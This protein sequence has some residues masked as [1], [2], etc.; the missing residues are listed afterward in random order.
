MDPSGRTILDAHVGRVHTLRDSGAMMK[1]CLILGLFALTADVITAAPVAKPD[2]GANVLI[3][4]SSMPA[5]TI[6]EQ[7]DKVCNTQ[8]NNEFGSERNVFLFMPG[9]YNVDV[10]IG[11]YTQILGLGASPD[12]VL[13]KGNVHADASLR[14]NNATTTFWRAAEGFSVTPAS[15]VMQWAV[16]QAVP[17][18]R[19]HV[20]G[21]IV[22][23]QN[24]GWASGGWMSDDMIDG[25]VGSGTQ[26]QWFSRNSEW[27]SW[28]GA[29]WN[30]VFQGTVNPP[31]GEWPTPPY[32]KI[33]Q[34]PIV[35]ESPSCRSMHRGAIASAF[36]RYVRTALALPGMEDRHRVDPS[37][38]ASSTLPGRMST[39]RLPSMR[40]W[41]TARMCC[42]HLA[43]TNSMTRSV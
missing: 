9:E 1:L 38:L 33:A 43:F 20:R 17:F 36:R 21:D 31:P 19:M 29:N 39:R 37:R 8:R 16:S 25:N 34:T 15:G 3:F 32:T 4:D 11:F 6:Q 42:S 22:L 7:V 14:N 13:I 5:K 12:N 10:P 26:Q 41:A 28:T 30:M 35:R 24:R 40:S 27:G 23:H 18:R 2:F